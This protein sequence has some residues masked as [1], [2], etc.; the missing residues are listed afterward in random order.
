MQRLLTYDFLMQKE[1]LAESVPK[2][3]RLLSAATP[4]L[5]DLK[6]WYDQPL[7][8]GVFTGTVW[9]SGESWNAAEGFA[10]IAEASHCLQLQDPPLE[11]MFPMAMAALIKSAYA[12]QMAGRTVIFPALSGAWH[13]SPSSGF[14]LTHPRGSDHERANDYRYRTAKTFGLAFPEGGGAPSLGAGYLFPVTDRGA[15]VP[16]KPST[17]FLQIHR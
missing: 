5:D 9:G 8:S 10:L 6:L 11:Y 3:A 2:L 7:I 17:C 12:P 13:G 14:L 1:T 4:W 16:M 15:D